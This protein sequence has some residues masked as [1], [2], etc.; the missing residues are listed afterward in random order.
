MKPTTMMTSRV[1]DDMAPDYR[2]AIAVAIVLHLSVAL[3]AGIL[4][5]RATATQNST[6]QTST[7]ITLKMDPVEPSPQP[8]AVTPELPATIAAEPIPFEIKT[9]EQFRRPLPAIEPSAN[10]AAFDTPMLEHVAGVRP[11]LKTSEIITKNTF[12][13]ETNIDPLS[14][15]FE[16]KGLSPANNFDTAPVSRG[17]IKPAYPVNARRRGE[18]GE[19]LFEILVN[20]HGQIA[21]I[22]LLNSSGFDELDGAAQRAIEQARFVP[23][24]QHGRTVAARV[25]LTI[26]FRLTD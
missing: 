3:V 6:K 20:E 18:E 5:H 12:A 10:V 26:A 22:K 7:T 25:Q 4:T 16:D 21:A 1:M 13:T 23:A 17:E 11:Q 2:L 15:S 19:A 9:Q 14:K 24:R 8:H